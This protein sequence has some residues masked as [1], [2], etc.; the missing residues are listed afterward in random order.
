MGYL[1]SLVLETPVETDIE[2]FARIVAA[3]DII[4]NTSGIFVR[5]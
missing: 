1:K 3:N 4:K 2:L 5:I